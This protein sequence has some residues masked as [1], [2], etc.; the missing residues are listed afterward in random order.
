MIG[1]EPH[2]EAQAAILRCRKRFKL[3]VGGGQ[4][5]KSIE[6]TADHAIHVFED[7]QRRPGKTLLYWLLA[8][9]YERNRR[10]WDYLGENFRNFG[11]TVD[12]SKDIHPGR[13]E[14]R[15][16]KKDRRPLLVAETKSGKDPRTLSMYSPDGIIICEASQIDFETYWKAQ[17]RV[18]A[19]GGWLHLSGTYETSYG[20][21]PGLAAAWEHGSADEQSFR[22]PSPT[23]KYVYP[24]GVNDPKLQYLKRNSSDAFYLE[25]VMGIASPPAGRVFK[26]FRADIHIRQVEYDPDLPLYIWDDPGYGH[27]HAIEIA[28]VAPGGQVRV[29]DE[30][31][32]RGFTT[33][34]LIKV[35]LDRPWWKNPH[36]TLV[37]DPNYATQHQGTHSVAEIWLERTQLATMGV[38]VGIMDGIE[39]FKTF[40]KVNPLTGAPGIV[41][42]PRCKGV[43]SELG[44]Y[45]SPFYD[46][47]RWE[48]YSWKV[49]KDG[50]MAGDSPDDRYN[51]GVK[52]VTYGIV[53]RFGLVVP[54]GSE[55]FVM[56]RHVET[57]RRSSRLEQIRERKMAGRW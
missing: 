25:K 23:N 40:L 51:D 12:A 38:K 35:C 46:P 43:L 56:K 10:E 15:I 42:A 27:A 8:A 13:M 2:S 30:I 32:D 47:P 21:Y 41:F 14:V 44:A 33:E 49:D 54:E 55:Y 52:A 50:N 17:E 37:I 7:K 5:G 48:V 34:D 22:L 36:K 20:W 19:S 6:A 57:H 29:F 3:V 9:D 45:P 26:E 11:Y 53:E 16:S 1:F 18:T 39:R 4:A 24:G 31:Y 28:Q